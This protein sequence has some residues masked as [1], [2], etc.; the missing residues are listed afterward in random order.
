MKFLI[1]H[2]LMNEQQLLLTKQ[3]IEKLP[4]EF[5]G[6][7]PFTDD[8]ITD[9]SLEGVDYIPYGS[10]RFTMIAS[11]RSWK[12]CHFDL[13]RFNYAA[14]ANVRD[15]MLNNEHIIPIVEAI[16]FL[17]EQPE[18]SLWFIRPSE[19]LK[20]FSGMVIEA[21]ECID[22]LTDA[23][24]C[25]SSGSY[26][27]DPDTMVVLAEPKTIQAEWRWFIVDGKVVSGSMYRRSGQLVKI[28]ETDLAV[29]A[30]AQAF[31]DKWLPDPCC[32][33]DI[34]LVDDQP[35]VIEFNC[36]NSSGFYDHD[37]GAIFD[38]LW[39]YHQKI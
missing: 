39:Q 22:F 24:E 14:A 37:I 3:A 5:V 4:H 29:I 36:I 8:I 11:Q 18:D 23:M 35:K 27:L 6:L 19:D 16:S 21:K 31:A 17:Q 1:Q 25:A 30:E 26:K 32:V 20:Q 34:A 13:T 28:Q 2:N 38:A 33:M 7:I 9:S 12:G 10:T 15:D